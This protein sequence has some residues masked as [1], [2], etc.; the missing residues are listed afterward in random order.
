MPTLHNKFSTLSGILLVSGTCIGAGMLALPVVTGFSGFLPAMAVNLICWIFMLITGLLFLEATLWMKEEANVLSM[1][2]RFF[3]PYGKWIAGAAFLFL[4]YCLEV[5]Y[6]AGGTPLFISQVESLGFHLTGYKGYIAFASLFGFIVFLG[7]Q[8][9]DR[10]NLILMI[11][12]V[13]S[14]F[15][16][17][18]LGSTEVQISFLT[19]RNWNAFLLAM[20]TLFS[21]YGYHNIIPSLTTLMHRNVHQLRKAIVIGTSLPFIIYT[22]W[23]WMIIGTIPESQ[24]AKA[25]AEG[26]PVTQLLHT[27]TGHPWIGFLATYFG[28]FALITSFLGVSLSMVDFLADGIAAKSQG[29]TR[30][31]LCLIV[32]IPPAIF[33]GSYPG[34]FLEALGIAGGFGEAILN[35]LLPIGMVWLGRYRFH[36]PTQEQVRG[37]KPLLLA[38]LAFTLLIIAL[39]T[40]HLVR[41]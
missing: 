35:G 30:I 29:W 20:P 9:I 2:A 40:Y 8:V 6:I 19:R 21:A 39:E 13:F 5:S 10:V 36:L 27:I 28:Y 16:L 7:S 22:L 12:L 41:G 11:A 33:A 3:G 38:L 25:V 23:Q 14:Y 31:L 34:I 17:I 15:L 32:F 1:A 37:G 24:I 4:Y 18:G 26:I